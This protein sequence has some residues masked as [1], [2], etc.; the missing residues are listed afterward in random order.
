MELT[1]AQ[2]SRLLNEAVDLLERA[3]AL[4][5]KALGATDACYETCTQLQNIIDDLVTDIAE[6]DSEVE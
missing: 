4:V 5:Q 6:F 3:D 1:N 2:K